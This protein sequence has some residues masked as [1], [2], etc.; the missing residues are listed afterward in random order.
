MSASK[1]KGASSPID[2]GW[3]YCE[4]IDAASRKVKCKL[5]G[6]V[7]HGGVSRAK[8]YT[9]GIAGQV[10]ACTEAS[11]EIRLLIRAHVTGKKKQI[12]INKRR[13]K[14]VEEELANIH[15]NES[16]EDEDDDDDDGEG[17]EEDRQFM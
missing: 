11:K 8:Q 9:A 15:D 6:K 14:I 10:T 7:M 17:D 13:Q 12:E 3:Q 2:I 16:E 1:N 4:L 5:C